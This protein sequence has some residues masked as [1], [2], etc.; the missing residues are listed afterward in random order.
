MYGI[1]GFKML[2]SFHTDTDK[3]VPD[4]SGLWDCSSPSYELWKQHVACNLITECQHSEDELGCGF[5]SP[6]CRGAIAYGDR[7][8]QF[9]VQQT[10]LSW[11]DA[12]SA[13]VSRS[14]DLAS[15]YTYRAMKTIVDI[16]TWKPAIDVY[17]GLAAITNHLTAVFEY[18]KF[19]IWNNGRFLI[20]TTIT[21][22]NFSTGPSCG[23]L[24]LYSDRTL[25]QKVHVYFSESTLK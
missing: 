5:T 15:F 9:H 16:I 18:R 12:R 20:E 4:E 25:E 6:Q 3:P 7:C 13:C 8:Y 21:E 17:I 14:G 19:Y 11:E 24:F 1:Y 23:K 2:F 10:P 22:Y